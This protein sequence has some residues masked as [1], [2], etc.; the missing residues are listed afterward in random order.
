[1]FIIFCISFGENMSVVTEKWYRDLD[2]GMGQAVAERTILRK[3]QDGSWETWGDVAIIPIIV[4]AVLSMLNAILLNFSNS[5]RPDPN[6]M[7]KIIIVCLLGIPTGFIAGFLINIA[8][9]RNKRNFAYAF[10]PSNDS[11]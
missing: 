7:I 6:Q 9:K 5:F 10:T 2:K 8:R 4:S 3:K 11:H 1:V